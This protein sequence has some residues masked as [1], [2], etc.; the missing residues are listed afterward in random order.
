MKVSD[1]M[2][3]Q[4][5]P[6]RPTDKIE[7][8]A[9]MIF[10][11]N[12]KIIPICEGKKLVGL[13]TEGDIL[14]HFKPTL[15][16]IISKNPDDLDEM[17]NNASVVL[18]FPISKLMN[19][20]PFTIST[21]SSIADAYSMMNKENVDKLLVTDEKG[22]FMGIISKGDVFKALVGAKALFTENEDYNDFLSKTYYST[23]DWDDRL[24]K[25]IPDLVNLLK[26]HNV[27]TILDVG[28]GTLS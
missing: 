22:N 7:K 26:K 5:T 13:L 25:E 1:L 10:G 14:R 24:K 20:K 18:S 4:Y 2:S 9:F 3:K 6:L 16:K 11:K 21:R 17:K 12:I 8:A 23:V 27:K 19:K 15:E 28:C